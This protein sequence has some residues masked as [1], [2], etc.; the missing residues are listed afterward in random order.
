MAALYLIA[1]MSMLLLNESNGGCND[2]CLV[3]GSLCF[4]HFSKVARLWPV[5]TV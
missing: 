1:P 4:Q 2:F 5:T 3:C